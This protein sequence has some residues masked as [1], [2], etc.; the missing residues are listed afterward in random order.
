MIRSEKRSRS[1]AASL[2]R[3]NGQWRVWRVLCM[4]SHPGA[5]AAAP[6]RWGPAMRP[7]ASG[8]RGSLQRPAAAAAAAAAA[9]LS[10]SGRHA[11]L[12]PEAP[13]PCLARSCD[14]SNRP[15]LRCGQER[16]TVR[17]PRI[18]AEEYADRHRQKQKRVC[19]CQQAL[20]CQGA[21]QGVT[22]HQQGLERNT[23]PVDYLKIANQG[24]SMDVGEA[25]GRSAVHQR[26]QFCS[27][28][29]VSLRG[30]M[31]PVQRDNYHRSNQ[32]GPFRGKA[33]RT[34]EQSN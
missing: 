18:L 2:S 17:A 27:R 7:C 29:G 13:I 14:L 21:C 23:L 3:L 9:T 31:A 25:Q 32:K 6:S 30:S 26:V 8:R 20:R 11:A 15:H 16:C 24:I 12:A 33:L 10:F 1:R 4:R 28:P 5:T 34:S 22:Q 19:L